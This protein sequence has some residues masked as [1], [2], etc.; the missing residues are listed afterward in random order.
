VRFPEN[1]PNRRRAGSIQQVPARGGKPVR[2]FLVDL[3]VLN[4]LPILIGPLNLVGH[5]RPPFL[6]TGSPPRS[7]HRW[8]CWTIEGPG[9]SYS[10]TIGILRSCSQKN[11]RSPPHWQLSGYPRR[12]LS[13]IGTQGKI[14]RGHHSTPNLTKSTEIIENRSRAGQEARGRFVDLPTCRNGLGGASDSTSEL[15][16]VLLV[17]DKVAGAF[18]AVQE[19]DPPQVVVLVLENPGDELHAWADKGSGADSGFRLLTAYPHPDAAAL[20]SLSDKVFC[21]VRGFYDGSKISDYAMLES[22][23]CESC[24][25]R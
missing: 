2:P 25:R 20:N 11:P 15:L 9:T 7:V 24:E 22:L 3:C 18:E 23:K 12:R 19:D 5:L 13:E 8:K 17:G 6:H 4:G 14:Q 1:Q 10:R 16:H 21:L